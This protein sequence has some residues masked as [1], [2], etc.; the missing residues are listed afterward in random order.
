VRPG[1]SALLLDDPAAELDAE[2]LRRLMAVVRKVPAQLWL[3]SLRPEI[4]ELLE[5]PRLFH[6]KQG[7]IEDF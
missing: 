4:A 3:T 1:R 2:N 7:E 5:S 6:V